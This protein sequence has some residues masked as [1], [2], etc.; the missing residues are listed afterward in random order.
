MTPEQFIEKWKKSK[1]TERAGSQ[2]HFLDLCLLLDEPNP[3]DADQL[4]DIYCFERGALKSNG[5]KGWADVW[6]KGHFGWE[7]KGKDRNLDAAFQQLQQYAIALENPPLLVVCDMQSII[8][9]TNFTN[10]VQEKHTITLDDLLDANKRQLLKNVFSNPEQLKPSRTRDALTKE[11]ARDFSTLAQQLRDKGHEAHAVAHFIN[12]LVFCMF[13]EDVE[14]LPNHMFTEMLKISVYKPNEFQDFAKQLF[15]AMK[16]G[17]LVG[18]QRI[19]YFNGGLFNDSEAL[20]LTTEQ[21]KLV[22]NAAM[23]DWSAIDPSIFGT[24]FERGLDP[25][26]RS[27]LGAHYTDH[28]KIM[29]IIRPTVLEPLER[30]WAEQKQAITDALTKYEQAKT[31]ATKTKQRNQAEK[32]KRAFMDRINAIRVLDP[33]CGSGNFLYLALQTLK[34]FEYRVQ[35]ECEALG[36]PREFNLL[37]PEVL[38]GIEINPYAAELARVSIWIGDIQWHRAKGLDISKNPIL[39]PLDVIEC[40]DAVLNADGTEAKWPEAEFIIGNPPFLGDKK[41]I[42]GLGE[43]YVSILRKIYK[44]RVPGGADLVCYWF[45]K[46][47]QAIK[48]SATKY[49]G[50]VTTKTIV[51]GKNRVVLDNLSNDAIIFNAWKNEPWV[52]DGASLRVS[53]IC[54]AD[55]KYSATVS[56]SLDGVA[57]SDIYTNLSSNQSG[58]GID[59]TLSHKLIE[60]ARCSY[61]GVVLVGKFEISDQAAHEWL[62]LPNNV[63][64]ISNSFVIKR[65]MNG[66]DFVGT[67]PVR[68][69]VDFG[70]EMSEH[71]AA[72]FEKPFEYAL[73]N[74]KPHRLRLNKDGSFAVRRE[75]HREYWWRYGESRPAMRKSLSGIKRALATPMVSRHRIFSWLSTSV[76]PDQKLVVFARDDDAFFGIM[77]SRFHELWSIAQCQRIG[78]GNDPTYSTSSIFETFPFPEGLTPNIAAADYAADP[79]AMAIAVAAKRLN[80]LRENWL[81][82]PDLV[83]R[84]PEVVEGYP[85]RILPKDP[86]AAEELKKRTLTKLYNQRPAWLDNAHRELDTAVAAAYG[87]PVEISDDEAL[88]MLLNLNLQRAQ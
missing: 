60:N 51:G 55:K 13:A 72:L 34:D 79:R 71:E 18:F 66:S 85:D 25:S 68:W 87:W 74:I 10:T 27:Q 24:L 40:R 86:R 84:K 37:G 9:Y 81:N 20:P 2:Q 83:V 17:G 88:R 59:I 35:L 26:K 63:H 61:V 73:Q 1:L 36:L 21:I 47:H 19:D 15:T 62:L 82:P 64:G 65:I 78:A 4:G 5:G 67:S 42:R 43:E 57:Q 8:I 29:M 23:K 41:M 80:E 14:L 33:A 77:H 7:Y 3:S 6:K 39:K 44:G 16:K 76:L 30:E 28:E 31:P 58:K 46:A 54:F 70:T 12:R 32:L 48:E 11:I 52:V 50:L 22:L 69:V 56:R 49:A 45:A 38:R 53:T 75:N